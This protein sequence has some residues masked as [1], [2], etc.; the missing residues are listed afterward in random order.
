MRCPARPRRD[1]LRSLRVFRPPPRPPRWPS[2]ACASPDSTHREHVRM[3]ASRF[4]AAVAALVALTVTG[5]G[6][7]TEPADTAGAAIDASAP[8]AKTGYPL[9]FDNCGMRVTFHKPPQRVL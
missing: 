4:A 5:C 8:A 1:Q 9:T 7:T 3:N 2:V 6:A